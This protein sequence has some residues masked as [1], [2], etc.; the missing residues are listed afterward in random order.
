M[1]TDVTAWLI[2]ERPTLQR[3]PED[4]HPLILIDESQD[5]MKGVLEALF[6]LWRNRPG[7]VTLGL[8][9]DHR[10]RIYPDGHDDLPSYVP[11]DWARPRCR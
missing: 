5:T 10:Q 2:R 7:H 8:L 3:I 11:E 4:Q 6:E 1:L 9:G